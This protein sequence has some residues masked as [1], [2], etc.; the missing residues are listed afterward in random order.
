MLLTAYTMRF[1]AID[2]LYVRF[3]NIDRLY[4]EVSCY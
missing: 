4:A 3:H 2:I 1:H